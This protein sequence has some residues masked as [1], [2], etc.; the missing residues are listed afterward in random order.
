MMFDYH[1]AAELSFPLS[2]ASDLSTLL[3]P[4]AHTPAPSKVTHGKRLFYFTVHHEPVLY[5]LTEGHCLLRRH[6]DN[7]VV[8][9]FF[10]PYIVGWSWPDQGK[11]SLYLERGSAGVLHAI[12]LWQANRLIEKNNQSHN[13][14][15][16]MGY[17]INKLMLNQMDASDR[18]VSSTVKNL[19]Q[20]LSHTPKWFQQQI[21]VL[22]YIEARTGL[23][24]SSILR[25]L[26]QLRNE[27]Y[28]LMDGG[29]L[30]II[31]ADHVK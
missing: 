7:R 27:G 10:A 6:S 28:V 22:K 24:R 4:Y 15:K 21:S 23:G 26:S 29:R 31:T 13:M 19:L 12:P 2:A 20:Q 3:L 30:E 1:Y 17:S 25:A 8:G 11:G 16:L 14:F 5:L 18:N 9:T